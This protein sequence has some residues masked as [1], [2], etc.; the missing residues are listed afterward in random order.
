MFEIY[1]KDLTQE[2]QKELLKYAE[3]ADPS[4]ANWDV[5]PVATIEPENDETLHESCYQIINEMLDGGDVETMKAQLRSLRTEGEIT[6]KQYDYTLAHW[7]ELL[8]C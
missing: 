3:I 1:F 2:A 8:D 4:E 7:D 6:E 5:F